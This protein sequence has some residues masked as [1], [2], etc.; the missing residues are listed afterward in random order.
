MFWS[1]VKAQKET[2]RGRWWDTGIS[3]LLLVLLCVS[4]SEVHVAGFPLFLL[5]CVTGS[6]LDLCC[7]T[8]GA[9]TRT[10][11]M[12][13]RGGRWHVGQNRSLHTRH[14]GLAKHCKQS[15]SRSKEQRG[16]QRNRKNLL[17]LLLFPSL[18]L[19]VCRQWVCIAHS[20]LLRGEWGQQGF[21]PAAG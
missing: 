16:E 10:W 6:A 15:C 14:A 13:R 17:L 4:S 11:C 3:S 19:W 1:S 21:L 2:A 7:G 12:G 8:T 5:L 9:L 20:E 18:S